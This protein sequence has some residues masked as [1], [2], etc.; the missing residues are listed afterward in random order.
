MGKYSS[1]YGKNPQNRLA[2]LACLLIDSTSFKTGAIKIIVLLTLDIDV[3]IKK[4]SS[5]VGLVT[6]RSVL[7][8]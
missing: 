4:F 8:R 3:R 7:P 1:N 2:C 6:P 5:T